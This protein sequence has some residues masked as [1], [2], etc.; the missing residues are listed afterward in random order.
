MYQSVELYSKP[1]EGITNLQ[2]SEMTSFQH[3]FLCGLIKENRPNKIVEVGV[4]AGGTTGVVLQCLKM[5]NIKATMY[6]VDLSERWY[7]NESYETGFAV[8]EMGKDWGRVTHEFLL[9]RAIPFYLEQIG[10]DID[11]LILDTTHC[12]PGELLDFIICLPYLKDGCTVVLHDTI[13]SHLTGVDLEIATKLLF[14]V[15]TANDKYMM[16]EQEINSACFPNI[17]AFKA[18]TGTRKNSN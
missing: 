13:E 5:L 11:F 10:K 8:K 9:G 6:S 15:V 4:S 3:A 1:E 16:R 2:Y 12:L 14:D 18:D 7:R 17:A